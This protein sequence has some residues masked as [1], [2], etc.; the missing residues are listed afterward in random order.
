MRPVLPFPQRSAP[1]AGFT[2]LEIIVSLAI[3]SIV[4]AMSIPA[5]L[6]DA[7]PTDMEAAADRIE[8]LFSLARDSAVGSATPITVTLDSITGRVWLDAPPS[9]LIAERE[10]DTSRMGSGSLRAGGSFGGGSTLGGQLRLGA[11]GSETGDTLGLPGSIRL[12]LFKARARFTFSPSGAAMG[13]SLALRSS[14]GQMV[15]I[16]LDP[17]NGRARAR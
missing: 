10:P 5:L 4:A 2:L 17:W 15:M 12:E 11:F 6:R 1:P 8:A 16:S 3:I 7:Q 13:D 14:T 9:D